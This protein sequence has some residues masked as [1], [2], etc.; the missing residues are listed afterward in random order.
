MESIKTC[1]RSKPLFTD[2]SLEEQNYMKNIFLQNEFECNN[3]YEVKIIDSN[4]KFDYDE[5]KEVKNNL[6]IFNRFGKI[7]KINFKFNSQKVEIIFENLHSCLK[8]LIFLENHADSLEFFPYKIEYFLAPRIINDSEPIND[9]SAKSLMNEKDDIITNEYIT[10]NFINT[11]NNFNKFD[12]FPIMNNFPESNED[13][14]LDLENM[15]D[16]PFINKK[17]QENIKFNQF[18]MSEEKFDKNNE[19]K[20]FEYGGNNEPEWDIFVKQSYDSEDSDKENNEDFH[21]SNNCFL[22]NLMNENDDF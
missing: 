5:F 2:I 21:C 18:L 10:N 8:S 20:D 19:N 12:N 11:L 15:L 3:S 17:N 16:V 9:H 22:D 7:K 13:D 1:L 6:K 14:E 4:E